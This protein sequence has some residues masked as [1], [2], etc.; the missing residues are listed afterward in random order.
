MPSADAL[1][2]LEEIYE[3]PEEFRAFCHRFREEHPGVGDSP[4]IQWYLEPTEALD[5]PQNLVHDEFIE[6][7]SSDW[8]WQDL[9][10]DCSFT[11]NNGLEIHAA[12]GRDLW[13]INLSAPRILNSVSGGFATQTS[14]IPA[15]V[16]GL[17]PDTTPAIG[18]ILLWK[19]KENYLRLDRGLRGAYEISFTGCIGNKNVFIGRGRL[20]SERIFLRLERC[21]N[22]VNS[23]CSADGIEWF[24]V[25]YVEFPVEE[26]V[27]I[28][29]YAIGNIERTIYNGAYPDGTAIRFE[30]FQL[31]GK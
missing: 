27:E 4:F 23:L 6:S 14:C 13:Y 20:P 30:S 15:V 25:G 9:F 12:N 24:T 11:V 29:L 19:D 21:G 31:W 3:K 18:G 10:G 16:S 17:N 26:P 5:F 8:V 28:G 2:R 22:R 7:L 1:S